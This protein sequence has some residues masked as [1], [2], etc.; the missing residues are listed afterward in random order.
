MVPHQIYQALTAQ[1]SHELQA[2]ARRHERM[3]EARFADPDWTESSHLRD[4]AGHL[5]GMFQVRR[6][7]R[8]RTM[9]TAQSAARSTTAQSA[10]RSTTAQS[11]ARPMG[12]VA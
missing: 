6:G 12:C 4:M 3:N 10:A 5:M 8:S 2:A 9:T 7:S 1:H 11:A